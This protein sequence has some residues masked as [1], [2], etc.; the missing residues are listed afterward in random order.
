MAP[1]PKPRTRTNFRPVKTA[2]MAKTD[3]HS[4]KPRPLQPA[5]QGRG[6]LGGLG[7]RAQGQRQHMIN[8]LLSF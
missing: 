7:L 1:L 6:V 3:R 8:R 2:A 5:G 4:T